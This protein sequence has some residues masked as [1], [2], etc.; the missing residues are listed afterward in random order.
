MRHNYWLSETGRC[1][2]CG[3]SFIDN[4]LLRF[5]QGGENG[6]EESIRV[7]CPQC[8]YSILAPCADAAP[9]GTG[10]E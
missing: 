9:N 7:S 1:P 10:P 6:T 5:E 2:K 3:D 8:G 4:T